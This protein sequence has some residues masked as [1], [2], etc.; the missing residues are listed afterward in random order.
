MPDGQGGV[1]PVSGHR[2]GI[3]S[4]G[5]GSYRLRRAELRNLR[6]ARFLDDDVL[7]AAGIGH[8][9]EHWV[10][11]LRSHVAGRGDRMD[12]FDMHW[13]PAEIGNIPDQHVTSDLRSGEPAS[14]CR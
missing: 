10:S 3:C 13:W 4:N 11:Q 5:E 7:V 12:T 9:R 1:T 8:G 14:V 6:L 2:G